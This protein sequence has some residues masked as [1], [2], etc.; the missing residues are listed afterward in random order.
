MQTA[1][2]ELQKCAVYYWILSGKVVF[3]RLAIANF[4]VQFLDS[5]NDFLCSLREIMRI[6]ILMML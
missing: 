6:E 2:S 3:L 4:N 1:P 5:D